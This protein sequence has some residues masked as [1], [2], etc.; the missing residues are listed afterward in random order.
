MTNER[1]V[2]LRLLTHYIDSMSYWEQSKLYYTDENTDIDK[3]NEE[4]AKIS[5]QIIA[6]YRLND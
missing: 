5:T 4:L 1:K 2:A 3:V 6:R